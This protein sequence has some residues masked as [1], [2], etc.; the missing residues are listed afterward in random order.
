[1]YSCRAEAGSVID[2]MWNTTFG[3]SDAQQG[4]IRPVGRGHFDAVKHG[5]FR[6][7]PL[8]NPLVGGSILM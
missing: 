3:F 1:M 6:L 8:W 7:P 4:L 5:V 2:F